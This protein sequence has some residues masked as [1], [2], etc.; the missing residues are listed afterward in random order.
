[1]QGLRVFSYKTEN[2]TVDTASLFLT[3]MIPTMWKLHIT[4]KNSEYW[5]PITEYLG[6]S[7][8]NAKFVSGLFQNKIFKSKICNLAS[9]LALKWSLLQWGRDYCTF[10]WQVESMNL[11]TWKY[12]G[13]FPTEKIHHSAVDMLKGKWGNP[14][15]HP[16][17]AQSTSR[18]SQRAQELHTA[19]K[20]WYPHEVQSVRPTLWL[21][22][23]AHTV[24]SSSVSFGNDAFTLGKRTW[25]HFK[26][27]SGLNIHLQHRCT[28]C[29][30][31]CLLIYR[32]DTWWKND[33]H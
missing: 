29:T 25:L 23:T 20:P 11:G 18:G 13:L 28:H 9:K 19:L 30:T 24:Y 32:W 2:K 6:V 10:E 15:N 5:T 22:I 33:C 12:Q 21:V 4:C 3:S 7:A 17:V 31:A 16:P 14:P 27:L 26:F 8:H 1:M